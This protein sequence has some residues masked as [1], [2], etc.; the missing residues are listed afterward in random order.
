VNFPT[1]VGCAIPHS[2][3]W[4]VSDQTALRV[5]FPRGTQDDFEVL[6]RSN[7]PKDDLDK[8][9]AAHD[10]PKVPGLQILASNLRVSRCVHRS[11]SGLSGFE[12]ELKAEIGPL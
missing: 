7:K 1:A 12:A 8:L 6:Q 2:E 5:C 10:V 4:Y 11:D 3:K 9:F